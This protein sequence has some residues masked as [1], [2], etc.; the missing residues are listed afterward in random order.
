[1]TV[2][3]SRRSDVDRRLACAP[4][5]GPD[6]PAAAGAAPQQ[7][8]GNAFF[9]K[10]AQNAIRGR[11]AEPR[12][13]SGRSHAHS[14]AWSGGTRRPKVW[15]QDRTYRTVTGEVV[16]EAYRERAI[17]V[18]RKQ[19]AKTAHAAAG[20]K[21][22]WGSDTEAEV[23]I[24]NPGVDVAIWDTQN[25]RWE[26]RFRHPNLILTEKT[27]GNASALRLRSSRR[28]SDVVDALGSRAYPATTKRTSA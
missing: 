28:S 3:L 6:K 14:G 16:V 13:T 22:L 10:A 4:P 26:E 2:R 17:E 21:D 20:T 9:T 25:P 27:R 5:G 18:C 11:L 19:S 1:M 24:G 12:S 8:A 23:L 7:R 15:N